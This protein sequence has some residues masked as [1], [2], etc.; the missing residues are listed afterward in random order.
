MPEIKVVH[1]K[2]SFVGLFMYTSDGW[3]QLGRKQ[4]RKILRRAGMTDDEAARYI[5]RLLLQPWF[6]K[7]DVIA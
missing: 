2:H 7:P 3:K 6:N 4:C 5:G 1:W